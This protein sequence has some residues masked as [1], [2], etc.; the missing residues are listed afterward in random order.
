M[1]IKLTARDIES[2]PITFPLT[3]ADRCD[4]KDCDAQALVRAIL[5]FSPLQFCG[6]HFA[7][8]AESLAVQGF[9]IDQDNREQVA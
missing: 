1:A 7:D 5:G 6:H 3:V 2:G 8:V 9:A 4:M